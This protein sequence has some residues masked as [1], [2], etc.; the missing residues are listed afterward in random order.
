MDL[1]EHAS[2][3]VVGTG[4]SVDIRTRL[5]RRTAAFGDFFVGILQTSVQR[6]GQT[7]N[8]DS[9]EKGQRWGACPN[10]PIVLVVFIGSS[11]HQFSGAAYHRAFVAGGMPG[12]VLP[13]PRRQVPQ[14]AVTAPGRG[15]GQPGRASD[16]RRVHGDG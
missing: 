14:G 10:W 12:S 3:E 11:S 8:N 5:I 1:V 2:A 9:A 6:R 13:P 16:A 7:V 4:P 15:V